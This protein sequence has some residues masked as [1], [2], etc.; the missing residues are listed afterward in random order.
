M[1]LRRIV[2]LLVLLLSY[3]GSVGADAWMI[4]DHLHDFHGVEHVCRHNCDA[5]AT[6]HKAAVRCNCLVGHNEADRLL[7]VASDG[8]ASHRQQH[9]PA[10]A[11]PPFLWQRLPHV[12]T[13]SIPAATRTRRKIPLAAA[14]LLLHK[15]LR[16]PPVLA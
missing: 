9:A 16:A 14:P 5:C 6:H 13:Q 1:K 2:Y 10:A 15:G 8:D 11:L 3:T 12:A 4:W 7:Y